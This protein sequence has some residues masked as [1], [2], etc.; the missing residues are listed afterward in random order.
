LAAGGFMIQLLPGAGE[1]TI[2]FI[3]KRIEAIPPISKLIE[4]GKTPEEILYAL[5]VE[6]NI[7]NINNKPVQFE[8]SCSK[9]RFSNGIMGLGKEEI[10]NMIEEDG[11][12][13][14]ACH[15]CNA[16]YHFSKEELQELYAESKV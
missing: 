9:E 8:C 15:F 13:E 1:E 10:N 7:K 12:A 16:H 5:L 4:S 6:E 2:R 14:T 11:E 3:E